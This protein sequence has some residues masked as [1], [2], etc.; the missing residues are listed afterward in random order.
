MYKQY[1]IK[2]NRSNQEASCYNAYI[3]SVR[4]I[5]PDI[6]V[7]AGPMA[8]GKTK[9]LY[10]L[11][12]EFQAT[13]HPFAVYKPSLDIRQ[14]GIRPRGVSDG[15]A[16]KCR[17]IDSLADIKVASLVHRGIRTVLLEEFHMFGYDH[18]R[19]P[20]INIFLPT[21]KAWG[22]AGI[23]LVYAAGLDLAASGNQFSIFTDAHS[24]GSNIELFSAKCEYPLSDNGPTCRKEAHNS[25]IYS[26]SLG[27]AY[28][29]GSLPDLLPEGGD[30]DCS[31]RAVCT[32]H[33]L[34][35]SEQ[36]INFKI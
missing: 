36:T 23:N 5:L 15:D 14:D 25:Q 16:Y 17:A 18:N 10:S 22:A 26:R 4:S 19:K 28:R 29:M 2:I 34:L 3:M 30:P 13:H 20:R 6:T 35:P 11:I 7:F 33:L 24:Y 1:N 8:S 9:A 31:Y 27:K 32:E 21:M 12:G